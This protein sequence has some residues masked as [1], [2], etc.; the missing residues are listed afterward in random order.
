[1]VVVLLSLLFLVGGQAVFA[2]GSVN[3]GVGAEATTLD[4]RHATDVSSSQITTLIYTPLVTWDGELN[5]VLE[6]AAKLENPDNRTYVFTLKEGILFHDGTEMTSEDVKYTYDT[7]R[8]PDFGARNIGFYRPIVDIETPDRY[9]VIFHLEEDNAPFIYY[10]N[11]GIVPK[12]YVQEYGDDYIASNPIGAGPFSFIEWVP[13]EYIL[14]EAFDDYFEGR[15]TIDRVRVRTIPDT[16]TK[17]VELQTGGVHIIDEIDS[18]HVGL[19]ERDPSVEVMRVLPTGFDYFGMHNQMAPF[20]DVRVRQAI[21]YAIPREDIINHIWYGTASEAYS[22]IIPHSWANE[23]Q[24]HRF[25]YNI[26]Q[27]KEL[28]VEA[29]YGDGFEVVLDISD[30]PLRRQISEIMQQELAKLNIDVTLRER[31]WGA[32]YNDVL[33]GNVK[34]F[35]LGWRAQ[36]DPDRGLYR[37][38]HSSNWVPH[39][40]N[41][42]AYKNE[43]VDELLDLARA[44]TDVEKR[45]ELYSEA[46]KI[47]VEEASYAF[48]AYPETIAGKLPEL[49][50]ISYCGYFY[51]RDLKSAWLQ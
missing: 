14:M 41:R 47:I 40:A 1:M 29:G 42:Q 45:K 26:E 13:G 8:D 49:Q 4:P 22:P 11:V 25:D 43:R 38:F 46:Q 3:V 35:I 19:L 20:D 7:L 28:L 21:A 6:A 33:E 36:T 23:P 2:G 18:I 9:T 32:F 50:G 39:G 34:F 16:I 12:H 17:T 31:E 5:I 30:N 27:A 48:I 24:V 51:F 44:I 10:M 37:Q 15:P